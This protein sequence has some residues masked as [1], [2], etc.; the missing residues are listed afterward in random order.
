MTKFADQLYD[1]LMRQH[2]PTLA[3]A[4]PATVAATA[5]LPAPAASSVRR[6]AMCRRDA[7]CGLVSASSDPC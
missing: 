7:A 4:R 2:G 6:G 3:A 5:R 1:D